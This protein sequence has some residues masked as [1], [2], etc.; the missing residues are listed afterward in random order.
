[1]CFKP[2]ID[3]LV[4][5]T[6]GNFCS[7]TFSHLVDSDKAHWVFTVIINMSVVWAVC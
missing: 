3:K 1:M 4:P 6:S 5:G 2:P 7:L